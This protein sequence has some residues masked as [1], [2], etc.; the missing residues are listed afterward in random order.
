MSSRAA[1]RGPSQKTATGKAKAMA[2]GSQKPDSATELMP[3]TDPGGALSTESDNALA[4]EMLGAFRNLDTIQ[5]ASGLP[6]LGLDKGGDW[7]YGLDAIEPQEGSYWA[8]DLATA[9][10]GF[11][12]WVDGKPAG[13]TM[14]SIAE[15]RANRAELDAGLPWSDQVSIEMVCVSGDDIGTRVIYKTSSLGGVK[16]FMAYKDACKR[17]IP[18]EPGKPIAVVQLDKS[19]YMHS[20]Y[21]RIT[22]PVFRI[23]GWASSGILKPEP[24]GGSA[25]SAPEPAAAAA[26][27]PPPVS[28][29]RRR[30][31]GATA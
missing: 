3:W 30:A 15:H 27:P 31:A 1:M 11:V 6:F 2:K 19:S 20:K 18:N 29:R 26:A 4:A 21:G 23:C 24:N 25:A 5:V 14:V 17:T 9:K 28:G 16:C 10:W 12:A 7:K 13:E 8:M 22:N